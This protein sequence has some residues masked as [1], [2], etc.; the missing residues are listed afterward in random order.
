MEEYKYID[1][2][3]ALER[4]C[5]DLNKESQLAVDIEMEANLHHYGTHIAMVQL[6]TKDEVWL[7][8][9][10]AIKDAKPLVVLFENPKVTKIFHDVSFDFRVLEEVL[11][12]RP[13]NLFDTKAA[14]ELLGK[15]S[16]SLGSLLHDYF[17]VVKSEKFQ[18]ADWLKR[19]LAPDLL[20]YA[21]G[22]VKKLILLKEYLEEELKA[23]GRLSWLAE[24]CRLF[25][26]H[27]YAVEP[28]TVHDVK[29]AANLSDNERGV[30]KELFDLRESLAHKLDR[31][32][33][34]IMPDKVMLEV[35]KNPPKDYAAWN[36]I[37]GVHPAVKRQA[38]R[39]FK[40]MHSAR[41]VDKVS[42]VRRK[43]L[44]ISAQKK[45]DDLLARRDKAAKELGIDPFVIMTREQAEVFVTGGDGA[46]LRD[47]QKEVLGL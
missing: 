17:G 39:F 26:K 31:P 3:A 33:F 14:A 5:F 40:A 34:F 1:S 10:L 9:M 38:P 24:E 22:D 37:R 32:V 8:D 25:E 36:R 43:R 18:K 30:L 46:L 11:D 45:V 29:G 28:K 13:V 6:G 15:D 47:W 23:K 16:V 4:L 42:K 44:H 21:A 7:V 35:A 19:P 2:D 12:C 20:A 27:S 41:P